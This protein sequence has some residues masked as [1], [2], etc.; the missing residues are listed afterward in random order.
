LETAVALSEFEKRELDRISSRLEL[1]DP[2]L[3]LLLGSDAFTAPGRRH[4]R[5][6]AAAILAGLLI[7]VTGQLLQVPLLGIIGFGIMC[8][9]GYWTSRNIRWVRRRPGHRKDHEERNAEQ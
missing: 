3:A 2:K 1:D 5:S 6:G 4:L 9:A 8:A 7:L